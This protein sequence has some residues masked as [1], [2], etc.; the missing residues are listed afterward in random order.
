MAQLAARG[1]LVRRDTHLGVRRQTRP[2]FRSAGE[3]HRTKICQRLTLNLFG[4]LELSVLP[5][6]GPNAIAL[7]RQHSLDLAKIY[8]EAPNLASKLLGRAAKLED[9][10]HN[11]GL[12][13]A[14]FVLLVEG[15]TNGP[16]MHSGRKAPSVISPCVLSIKGGPWK[17]WVIQSKTWG[18]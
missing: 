17:V 15:Q 13:G 12:L 2:L 18:K 3:L 14:L 7:N 4:S 1:R 10:G 5:F 11:G 6:K 9:N 8:L 16:L